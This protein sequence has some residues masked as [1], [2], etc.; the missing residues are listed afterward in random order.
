MPAAR[1][2]DSRRRIYQLAA[3]LVTIGAIAAVLAAVLGSGSTSELRPGR[4]VP[5]SA[6]TL[7]MLAGIPQRGGSL[8]SP[9]APATLFEFGDLQCPACAQFATEALPAIVSSYVRAGRV[10]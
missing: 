6:Q 5:G 2:R 8:G 1:L 3:L 7:S 4:P 10:L 9:A